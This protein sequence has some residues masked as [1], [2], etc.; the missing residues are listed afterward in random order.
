MKKSLLAPENPRLA[1]LALEQ[2]ADAMAGRPTTTYSKANYPA[3]VTKDVAKSIRKAAGLTQTQFAIAIGVTT[4]T[5][6]SWEQGQRKPDG[7]ASKLFRALKMDP[8]MLMTL[9]KA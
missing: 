2:L 4:A 7:M 5:V 3:P 9:V 1:R 6:R 8:K